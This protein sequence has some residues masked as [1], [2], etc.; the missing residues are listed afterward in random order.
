MFLL[1]RNRVNVL[2][3]VHDIFTFHNVSINSALVYSCKN[4]GMHLHSTMFLLIQSLYRVNMKP[5]EYLH[6][7]MFLL[8]P[9]WDRCLAYSLL[10]FTFHNVS[11]NSFDGALD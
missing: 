5:Q 4:I 6:S 8:I 9:P 10:R 7:T 1:I 11:I 2:F 3:F